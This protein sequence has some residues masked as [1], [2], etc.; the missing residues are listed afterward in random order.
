MRFLIVCAAAIIALY[1][2]SYIYEPLEAYM[3]REAVSIFG[4]DPSEIFKSG[5]YFTFYFSICVIIIVSSILYFKSFP[6]LS[7]ALIPLIPMLITSS[8]YIMYKKHEITPFIEHEVPIH[9]GNLNLSYSPMFGAI[10]GFLMILTF[11]YAK[12]KGSQDEALD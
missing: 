7:R 4:T 12:H 11:F 5:M 1:T 9:I 10:S 3:L 6:P 2:G 8:V